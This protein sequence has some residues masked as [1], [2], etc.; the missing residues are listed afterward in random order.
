MN[1]QKVAAIVPAFNEERNVANVLKVILMSKEIDEVILVDDCS[2]DRT[3]QIAEKL[4]A[5]VVSLQENRGKANAMLIGSKLTDAEIIVFFDS[6]LVGLSKSHISHLLEPLLKNEVAMC[7]GIRDRWWGLP[8]IIAKISPIM[9][10]IGGERAIRPFVIKNIPKKF[11]NNL[12]DG[13]IMNYYCKINKLPVKYIYLKGL[14]IIIK[15]K[16]WG[17][18]NSLVARFNMIIEFIKIRI[19]ISFHK[20]EFLKKK[21]Q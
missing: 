6:D 4:G 10:T 15:E 14:D 17:A 21:Y 13:V 2:S 1:G 7:V 20:K 11:F 8:K 18:Y 3:P 5:R 19:I 16:K 12:T 9:F